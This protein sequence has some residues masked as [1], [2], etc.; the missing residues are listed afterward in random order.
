VKLLPE[1]SLS[2]LKRPEKF[3]ET[4]V[5]EGMPVPLGGR[6]MVEYKFRSDI[7]ACKPFRRKADNQFIEPAWFYYRVNDGPWERLLL[8]EVPETPQTGEYDSENATF[9]NR[10]YQAAQLGNKVPF[11]AKLPRSG[12]VISRQ[13][14]GGFFDIQTDTLRKTVQDSVEKVPLEINDR[15]GYYIAIHDCDPAAG[16]QPGTSDYR[17]KTIKSA[18]DVL[19]E[20][21]ERQ[22]DKT[23]ERIAE[24]TKRQQEIYVKPKVYP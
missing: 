13:E 12:G 23:T 6:F 4:Q 10:D 21:A 3:D 22:K 8:N 2:E 14:G 16:R 11:A 19:R 24:I 20:L 17:E 1:R 5:L 18:E 9:A 7:G 15:I